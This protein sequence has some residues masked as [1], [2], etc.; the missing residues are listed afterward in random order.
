MMIPVNEKAE[1]RARE[2]LE[3]THALTRPVDLRR[4]LAALK[5][6]LRISPMNE[7]YS[8]YLAVD[9]RMIVVNERHPEVR[10]RFTV[11]H[12]IGHYDL[13]RKGRDSADMFV[14]RA[15]YFQD[16]DKREVYYRHHH[17]GP[18]DYRMEVEAN[19]YAAGLLMPE[20]LLEQYLEQNANNIDLSKPEGV[21]MAADAFRVSRLA[22]GYRLR[23]LGLGARTN[24]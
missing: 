18:A 22:M 14:D 9:K 16:D 11:A 10:R 8:G 5:L 6:E 24:F 4:I 2:M 19:A 15:D 7:A 23:N 13:H 20:K 1:D 17:F 12:E 21:Q 3:K